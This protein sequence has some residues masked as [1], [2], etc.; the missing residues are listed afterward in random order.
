MKMFGRQLQSFLKLFI[1]SAVAQATTAPT[2]AATASGDSELFAFKIPIQA[3]NTSSFLPPSAGCA[4]SPL[5]HTCSPPEFSR[6]LAPSLSSSLS[7]PTRPLLTF[8][9]F[10]LTHRS[11]RRPHPADSEMAMVSAKS[12]SRGPAAILY[13]PPRL[14][15]PA[16]GYPRPGRATVTW[17]EPESEAMRAGSRVWT[18]LQLEHAGG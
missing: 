12:A 4:R 17:I 1:G 16:L 13:R 18:R 14:R 3:A 8:P 10:G 7:R 9:S 5:L 6:S 11:D 2:T 15:P